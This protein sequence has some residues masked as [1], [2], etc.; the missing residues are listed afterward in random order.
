MDLRQHLES[1]GG[2]ILTGTRE[3]L[4][5]QKGD[6]ERGPDDEEFYRAWKTEPLYQR[7]TRARLR[8]LLEAIESEM[9]TGKTESVALPSGLSI[10]HLLP[11]GW[12]QHWPLPDRPNAKETRESLLHTIGNL[13]LVTKRLNSSLSNGPWIQKR[14]AIVGHSVLRLNQ[15]FQT[16]DVWDED[17]SV[18]R[19]KTLFEIAKKVWPRP[20]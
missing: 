8:M 13:T 18:D 11:Q 9:R 1:N 17:Q 7:L 2:S 20:S 15:L 14:N 3:F 6:S 4:L 5:S 19:G 10:E 16:Q 12:E